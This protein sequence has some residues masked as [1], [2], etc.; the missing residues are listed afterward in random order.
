MA[1]EDIF[2][3]LKT[4]ALSAAAVPETSP[5]INDEFDTKLKEAFVWPEGFPKESK[6]REHVTRFYYRQ[7]NESQART[8]F[9][10]ILVVYRHHVL[11]QNP[12]SVE[13][14][15]YLTE[16]LTN[17]PLGLVT[18]PDN[19]T[20]IFKNATRLIAAQQSGPHYQPVVAA[21]NAAAA[22]TDNSTA[23]VSLTELE[24]SV[25]A[26]TPVSREVTDS[27]NKPSPKKKTRKSKRR[28][29]SDAKKKE[30]EGEKDEAGPTPAPTPAPAPLAP[31]ASTPALP[32]VKTEFANVLE[33]IQCDLY[34][35]LR[36][37]I[38][39][40]MDARCTGV[41]KAKAATHEQDANLKGL[42]RLAVGKRYSWEQLKRDTYLHC[43]RIV[44]PG[45]YFLALY[46]TARAKD[47]LVSSWC[48]SIK[49][50]H[51]NLVTFD[52][53][54]GPLSERDAVK[55][56]G[57][58]FSPKELEIVETALTTNHTE[59]WKEHEQ[60]IKE[61][62]DKIPLESALR[63][64]NAIDAAKFPAGYDP[65]RHSPDALKQTLFAYAELE[66]LRTQVASLESQLRAAK[67][68]P[69]GPSPNRTPTKRKRED[70]TSRD[71]RKTNKSTKA[72][73][74]SSDYQ[75]LMRPAKDGK[76]PCHLCAK[77]G[78]R[79]FHDPK[80]CDSVRRKRNAERLKERNKGT[81][82]EYPP[83]D[84]AN[85]RY[86]E[87]AYGPNACPWCKRD[88]A[89]PKYA[90]HPKNIC[91]RRPGGECDKE[92]AKTRV[93]RNRVVK[94]LADAKRD[95]KRDEKPKHKTTEKA[96]R[97]SKK[98]T[99]KTTKVSVKQAV[100]P[101]ASSTDASA[102]SV[103]P[104]SSTWVAGDVKYRT[105]KWSRSQ[106][107][108]DNPFTQEELTFLRTNAA[109]KYMSQKVLDHT[110]L[111][112]G[113]ERKLKALR[114][115]LRRAKEAKAK[116]GLNKRSK[117][118]RSRSRPR[119]SGSRST[120][121]T[122]SSNA[123]RSRSPSSASSW[124]TVDR[125]RGKRSNRRDSRIPLR[126]R[127]RSRSRNRHRRSRS[128]DYGRSRRGHSRPSQVRQARA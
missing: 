101:Q 122:S 71:S 60:S 78:L 49:T 119:R 36:A 10:S 5:L 22:E 54:W 108:I 50:I 93:Q 92:K 20:R 21:T 59:L 96:K 64:I 90:D 102:K 124:Q 117:R 70:D 98:A 37:N 115:D 86:P 76:V 19:D 24:A 114:E 73:D 105:T 97:G 33:K 68:S 34:L 91:F 95:N 45:Y 30:K 126:R 56:L 12:Y 35:L 85:R 99:F 46:T 61:F 11:K 72:S 65:A 16:Y 26:T 104:S 13:K 9:H 7:T 82:E 52:K 41:I 75:A 110:Y 116:A 100:E 53:A 118:S 25:S 69:K 57:A 23:T 8:E 80:T 1:E 55:R 111:R 18:Y 44:T 88:D 58:F 81:P 15:T 77:V 3:F 67:K 29:K 2:A 27:S 113:K 79:L 4:P 42:D 51:N 89:N 48:H 121:Q 66:K 128:R 106:Y 112:V 6:S 120:R 43:C 39:R 62:F 17:D 63:I 125:K 127:S 74:T 103:T 38:Y 84:P 31:P 32:R 107:A 94:R 87:S 123:R 14:F 83:K 109:T 28:R 40:F 47:Q